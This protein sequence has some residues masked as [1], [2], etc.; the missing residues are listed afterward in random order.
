MEE[1]KWAFTISLLA[2]VV[3]GFMLLK[4]RHDMKLFKFYKAFAII[5]GVKR[6]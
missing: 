3:M 1:L 5:S 6:L 2:N 4:T